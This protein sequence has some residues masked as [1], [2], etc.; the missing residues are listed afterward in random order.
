MKEERDMKIEVNEFVVCLNVYTIA[1]ILC[2]AIIESAQYCA[3]HN[4]MDTFWNNYAIEAKMLKDMSG[5]LGRDFLYSD[6]IDQL[7][8]KI[9]FVRAAGC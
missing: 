9:L 7:E 1:C 8:K 3:M 5:R 6:C 4:G 2:D